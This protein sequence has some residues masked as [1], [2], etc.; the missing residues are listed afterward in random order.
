MAKRNPKK[1]REYTYY[2]YGTA[3]VEIEIKAHSL[4]EAKRKA[5]EEWLDW[6]VVG[7]P[8]I[9]EISPTR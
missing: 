1:K 5:A 2:A 6:E 8:K 4:E 9:I 3:S 7:P